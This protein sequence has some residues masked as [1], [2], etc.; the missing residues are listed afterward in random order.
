MFLLSRFGVWNM[1]ASFVSFVTKAVGNLQH[2]IRDPSLRN[3]RMGDRIGIARGQLPW[4]YPR[5]AIVELLFVYMQPLRF[6][7]CHGVYGGP[8]VL[9]SVHCTLVATWQWNVPGMPELTPAWRL[10]KN[11]PGQ[12]T[13]TR[14]VN[15]VPK[16]GVPLGGAVGGKGR[17]RC[18]MWISCGGLQPLWAL[19]ITARQRRPRRVRL[20]QGQCT[21][22][23][24]RWRR[25]T[26]RIMLII[27]DQ[28]WLRRG[29]LHQ[30]NEF[31]WQCL[32]FVLPS[33]LTLIKS[34]FPFLSSPRHDVTMSLF[35][36]IV[37]YSLRRHFWTRAAKRL[38]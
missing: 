10:A 7:G 1:F 30:G 29:F 26:V 15:K 38:K 34:Q 9:P 27:S 33:V 20:P 12:H 17:P 8:S 2:A 35:P 13:R 32:A 21:L 6:D 22:P 5:H 36:Q 37:P 3:H 14:D 28:I 25:S 23:K 24:L 16:S 19:A 11:Q 18:L 4:A 31:A